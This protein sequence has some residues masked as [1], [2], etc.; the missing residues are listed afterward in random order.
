LDTLLHPSF[1]SLA[2]VAVEWALM[3]FQVARVVSVEVLMVRAQ[4]PQVMQEWLTRAAAAAD[5][6]LMTLIKQDLQPQLMQPQL[7][8]VVLALLF[9]V[10]KFDQQLRRLLESL[11]EI[12]H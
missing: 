4:S 6:A 1:I 2:A 7:A 11:V 9:F 12:I 8:Q 5:L 3:V 10:I